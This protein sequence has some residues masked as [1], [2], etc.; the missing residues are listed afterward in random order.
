MNRC[1]PFAVGM[2][3][4]A[5]LSGTA[6]ADLESAGAAFESGDFA[7]ARQQLDAAALESNPD[8]YFLLGLMNRDGQGAAANP[9]EA[10]YD[11]SLA[12]MRGEPGMRVS[13]LVERGRAAAEMTQRQIIDAE[14]RVALEGRRGLSDEDFA[15]RIADLHGQLQACSRN[16]DAITDR[17]IEYGPAAADLIPDLEALMTRD[18]MWMPRQSYAATLASIGTAAVPALTRVMLDRR[19]LEA[20]GPWNTNT[21]LEALGNMGAAAAEARPGI[22]TVLITDFDVSSARFNGLYTDLTNAPPDHMVIDT[23]LRAALVLAQVGD[24]AHEVHD[25]LVACRDHGCSQLNRLAAAAAAAMTY[26]ENDAL[27]QQMATA[28]A[29]DAPS[30]QVMALKLY[31]SLAKDPVLQAKAQPLAA[32]VRKL[33]DATTSSAVRTV[34]RQALEDIAFEPR[35]A[36]DQALQD[37]DYGLAI[38]KATAALAV[39]PW[40]IEA[41]AIRAEARRAS[42]DVSGAVSDIRSGA[43]LGDAKAQAKLGDIYASGQG[44][45]QDDVQALTWM[46]IAVAAGA[47]EAAPHRDDLKSRMTTVQQAEAERRVRQWILSH[48]AEF[49]QVAASVSSDLSIRAL[50]ASIAKQYDKALELFGE[51]LE[52]TPARADIF[53]QRSITYNALGKHDE[54]LA[55]LDKAISLTPAGPDQAEYYRWRGDTYGEMNDG[56]RA[57]ADYGKAISLRPMAPAYVSRAELLVALGRRD[58]AIADY[59]HAL[60]LGTEVKTYGDFAHLLMLKGDFPAVLDVCNKAIAMQRTYEYCYALSS[61]ALLALGRKEDASNR[62]REL[63]AVVPNSYI[64]HDALGMIAFSAGRYDEAVKELEFVVAAAPDN[65]YDAM[66]MELARR[67]AG[68]PS[69]LAEAAPRLKMKGW[70]EPLVQLLLGASDL[71]TVRNQASSSEQSCEF[72]FYAGEWLLLQG[73]RDEARTLLAEAVKLCPN[74]YIERAPAISELQALH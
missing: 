63:M 55:D 18:E 26:G 35:F 8:G 39:D 51:A 38:E 66:W 58:D 13:A 2:F 10:F 49:P 24:P 33:A 40:S 17:I 54:A 27:M 46:D 43:E 5:L 62:L 60:A 12:M 22:V 28:L 7:R 67:R 65:A 15:R 1:M 11:F 4:V 6:R 16:C 70:P 3:L 72:G 29:S 31:P 73:R 74:T 37:K 68:M 42:G 32:S 34:A 69:V 44:L 45:P 20:E 47:G 71:E 14:N 50:D 36:A 59:Q 41:L 9:S 61:R 64:G 21:A 19:Q 25:Q 23:K 52:L 53:A 30:A 48:A 56:D 57:L